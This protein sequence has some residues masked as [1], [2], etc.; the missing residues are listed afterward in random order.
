M[1]IVNDKKTI[2]KH[3]FKEIDNPFGG[4]LSIILYVYISYLN[5]KLLMLARNV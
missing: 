4:I 5:K 3:Q 2:T 1:Q